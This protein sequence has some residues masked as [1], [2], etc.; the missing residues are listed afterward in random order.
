MRKLFNIF[1]NK[2]THSAQEFF[3]DESFNDYQ[4][5]KIVIKRKKTLADIKRIIRQH[6]RQYIQMY[7]WKY[8]IFFVCFLNLNY[9]TTEGWDGATII[10]ADFIIFFLT[11]W[12]FFMKKYRIG[13][14]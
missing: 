2:R 12:L 9:I 13:I 11:V 7:D 10:V 1:L 5:K 6:I 3:Y 4:S 14:R 8:V